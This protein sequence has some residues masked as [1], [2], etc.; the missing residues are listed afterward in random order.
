MGASTQKESSSEEEEG[1][2]RRRPLKGEQAAYGVEPLHL[3]LRHVRLL[4]EEL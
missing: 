2:A 4:Q 1:E 3:H